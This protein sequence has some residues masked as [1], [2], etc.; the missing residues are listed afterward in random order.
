MFIPHTKEQKEQMLKTIGVRHFDELLK[1]LPPSLLRPHFDLP[2]SLTEMELMRH[3]EELSHK[4]AEALSFLGAGAYEHHIPASVWPLT[5]RGEFATAYTP[6]QAEASQ[7]TLQTI[8]EFQ[9]LVSDLLGM[10]VANASMYDGASAAAEAALMALRQ[11]ERTTVLL[12]ETVHP[13]TRQVISSYLAESGATVKIIPCPTGLLEKKSLSEFLTRETAAL[14]LQTPNFFGG[15]E[16]APEMAQLVHEKGA[17]LVTSTYPISLG[18][19]AP[20][21]E[22]GADIAVAEGQPLGLP[23]SYGGPYVGYFACKKETIR[24]MPGR[25]VGQTTDSQGQRAFV[26]TLQ[27]REQHIRREKAT[28]NICTNQA[29]CALASTVAMALLGKSGLKELSELNFQK[30]HHTA[31]ELTKAGFPLTFP[32]PFFNEFS[33]RLPR[34]AKSVVEELAKDKILAGYALGRSYPHLKN[35]LLVC[36]TEIKTRG[37]IDQFIQSLKKVCS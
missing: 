36:V 13:H 24:K 4:N 2:S 34:N 28:S 17:L 20:P 22:Y 6:Y 32:N 3:L 5:L 10:E 19:L 9:T 1:G 29:L 23:L 18:L 8:Y 7:G 21:G 14:V 25:V 15:L 12:P 27:A 11:T 35:D 16:N 31:S 33:I 37:D 30:A 26:L